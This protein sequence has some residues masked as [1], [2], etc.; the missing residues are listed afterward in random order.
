MVRVIPVSLHVK[1][2]DISEL[3]PEGLD[4]CLINHGKLNR[5]SFLSLI[6]IP[7][8]GIRTSREG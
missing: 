1:H 4:S 5:F 3:R 2:F 8:T 6:R 7:L